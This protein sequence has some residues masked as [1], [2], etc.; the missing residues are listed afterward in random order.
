MPVHVGLTCMIQVRYKFAKGFA[1]LFR[2]I[3]ARRGNPLNS[4]RSH[5]HSAKHFMAR[6]FRY[7]EIADSLRESITNGSFPDGGVLPSESEL[8]EAHAASRVTIRRALEQLRSEGLVDS[9]QGFGWTVGAPL[10]Q[11][12]DTLE[13]IEHQLASAGRVGERR[14]LRFGFVQAPADVAD[15]LGLEVLEVV[16]LNLADDEP[17]AL[18]S[19]WCDAELGSTMSRSLVE[20]STFVDLLHPLLGQA[21]QIIGAVAATDEAAAALLVEP[22]SPLLRVRR[23]TL[24][25]S[26]ETALVSEHLYPAHRTEFEVT[27]TN[28]SAIATGLRLVE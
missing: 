18:V 21:T 17:F 16:R 27:L 8:S 7:T 12:L 15:L 5:I 19:V 6:S 14:V 9:R 2:Q 24:T 10:R 26:G 13:T 3:G 28:P 1:G 4:D 25:T 22:G 23:V 20:E 11:S